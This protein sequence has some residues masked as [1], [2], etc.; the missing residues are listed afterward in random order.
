MPLRRFVTLST[1]EYWHRF[2]PNFPFLAEMK[3]RYEELCGAQMETLNNNLQSAYKESEDPVNS[4]IATIN[5]KF[6]TI[7]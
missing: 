4:R 2:N 1:A 7:S 6:D 5:Q 3:T